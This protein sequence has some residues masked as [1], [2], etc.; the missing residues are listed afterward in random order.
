M[1]S[2][3]F[4]FQIHQPYRLKTFR[5]FDIGAD[6]NYFDDYQNRTIIKRIVERSYLPMNKLLLD[7]INE[8][9]SAF[10]VSF[11]ISGTAL[12]Q[13]EQYAPEA[14]H[15]FK[16][17]AET[18]NVEF[19]AETYAHSLISL[20]DSN[21]FA[22][23]V[24][25]H[26]ARIESLFGL[27]PT[28][29]RN[30]ELIYSDRIGEKV[31]DMGY[32]VMLTEG[33]KHILGWKSPDFMYCN[34]VNP[35]LKVLLR[36]FQLSDDI[37][38]RFSNQSWSEW[39]LTAEKFT[40]WLQDLDPKQQ[41]VNLFLDYET[42]GEHQWA[43]TGIFDFM[44]KLPQ[45][46]LARTKYK[47][48]TPAGLAA[49]LQPVSAILVPNTIS[50]ADE[51][52]DLT[53]WLGN[54][55]QDEAFEALYKLLPLAQKTQ[56]PELQKKWLYLQTSD[57]FYYMCTKWF[58]DGTVHKYFNP[59]AS[60]YEAFINYMNVLS[61]FTIRLQ[62][63]SQHSDTPPSEV[64]DLYIK[65]RKSTQTEVKNS[66][67]AGLTAET[68]SS[69]AD[70]E[71]LFSLSKP[72]V[73]QFIKN[74]DIQSLAY[75]IYDRS[76]AELEKFRKKLPESYNEELTRII[77]EIKRPRKSTIEHHKNKISEFIRSLF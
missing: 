65:K 72:K 20:Y 33:A 56:N 57:H 15:S 51:E 35:K 46:I 12:D 58:S 8:Y 67:Q 77:S 32:N 62:N 24:A 73:K 69:I 54:D 1:R 38:F 49:R 3:C 10:K 29:F 13:F 70:L 59:Y 47:F 7:L 27:K 76:G 42:F 30:T 11:S 2:I 53:A 9:G 71:V 16:K 66:P 14:L 41:V 64:P 48:D 34:A 19:L 31:Y 39:P 74:I 50:W 43:E 37:G 18:G 75:S 61:D 45:Q 44:K 36:N 4:Y 21:E 40:Q 6:D 68:S 60:P 17:L 28:S 25:K 52:R 5:F 63:D 23:Q 22:A 26:S 55:M